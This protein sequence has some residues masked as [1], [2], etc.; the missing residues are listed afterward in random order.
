MFI[1]APRN[2]SLRRRRRR[3]WE[4]ASY[5]HFASNEAKTRKTTAIHAPHTNQHEPKY[6]PFELKNESPTEIQRLG[7]PNLSL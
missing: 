1:D 4:D 5:K 3:F 2:N 6:I 7:V